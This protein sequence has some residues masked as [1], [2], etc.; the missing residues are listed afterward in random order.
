MGSR[1]I[2]YETFFMESDEMIP[3]VF[4]DSQRGPFVVFSLWSDSPWHGALRELRAG[5]ASKGVVP[6]LE[7]RRRHMSGGGGSC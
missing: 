2:L 1:G 6:P 7:E 3:R 5:A 4:S